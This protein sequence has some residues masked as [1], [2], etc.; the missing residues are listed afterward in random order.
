M[1]IYLIILNC[2]PLLN[3]MLWLYILHDVILLKIELLIAFLNMVVYNVLGNF[4]SL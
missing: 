4:V 3:E 2:E 1:N